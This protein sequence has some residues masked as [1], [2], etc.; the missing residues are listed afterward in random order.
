M[1]REE[2]QIYEKPVLRIIELAAEET[3][4]IGCK[5]NIAPGRSVPTCAATNCSGSGS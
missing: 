3:L 5:S 1:E 2:K 4:M